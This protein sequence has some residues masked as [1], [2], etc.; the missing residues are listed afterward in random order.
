MLGDNMKSDAISAPTATVDQGSYVPLDRLFVPLDFPPFWGRVYHDW[1]NWSV[2]L[3]KPRVVLLAEAGSGKTEEFQ[4][5]PLL[6]S[7]QGHFAVDVRI[8]HLADDGLDACL[9]AE[10][11]RQLV[12]W[13]AGSARGYFVH[14][15]SSACAPFAMR[16]S[17]TLTPL[18]RA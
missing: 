17:S 14:S 3:E 8:E 11:S 15:S 6:L 18:S 1:M 7:A 16:P 13:K 12:A 10:T 9:D 4:A 5:Q 2:L